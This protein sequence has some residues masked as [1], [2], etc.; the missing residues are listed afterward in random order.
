MDN[1]QLTITDLISVK[2]VIEAA[3]NRGAFKAHEMKQVGELYE[4]LTGF[5]EATQAHVQSQQPQSEPPLQ[6]EENA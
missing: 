3:C 1:S 4:K 5:I 6:G 2:N